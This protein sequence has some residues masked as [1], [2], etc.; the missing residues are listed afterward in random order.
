MQAFLINMLLKRGGPALA[1]YIGKIV[2]HGLTTF[3]GAMIA[4]GV[5]TAND[6]DLI[7]G[8]AM[9]LVGIVLSFIRTM[10]NEKFG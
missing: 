10:V 7:T 1:E 8:G 9:A 6:I 2:R 3:G 4:N 5:A